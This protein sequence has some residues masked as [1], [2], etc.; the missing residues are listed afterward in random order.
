MEPENAVALA[1]AILH[2]HEHPEIAETLGRRGRAFVEARFAREQ[3][4]VEL[5][6]HLAKLLEK[7]KPAS[8]PPTAAAMHVAAEKN[9]S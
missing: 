2:L 8:L 6:V 4:T 5:Q 9:R 3:L 7:E 1:S